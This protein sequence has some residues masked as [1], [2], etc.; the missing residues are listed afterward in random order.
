MVLALI[1]VV[2]GLLAG[3]A[4]GGSVAAL[5]EFRPVFWWAPLAAAV[6]YVIPLLVDDLGGEA[7]L[8]AMSLLVLIAA[9]AMNLHIAGLGVVAIGL[10]LNLVPLAIDG[11]TTV[12]PDAAATVGLDTSEDLGVA[13]RIEI[14][15]DRVG[16]LGDRIPVPGLDWLVSFGDLIVLVGL[17]DV[18]LRLT[19]PR[20]VPATAD[21]EETSAATAAVADAVAEHDPWFA[22]IRADH[23]ADRLL[24]PSDRGAAPVVEEHGTGEIRLADSSAGDGDDVVPYVDTSPSR[25]DELD[26]SLVRWADEPPPDEA[27]TDELDLR[28][29]QSLL[30]ADSASSPAAPPSPPPAEPPAAPGHAATDAPAAG[31]SG[32]PSPP[33]KGSFGETLA[34]FDRDHDVIDLDTASDAEATGPR[35]D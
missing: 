24:E 28:D 2:V 5:R 25:P 30:D 17:V 35:P 13:R 23:G 10:G 4:T 6:L 19:R 7:V 14:T 20:P 32:P 8:A 31:P 9:A 33:S 1:A 11:A 34:R 15:E 12:G 27:V 16:L 29:L 26:L 22:N 21:P 18:G 3:L